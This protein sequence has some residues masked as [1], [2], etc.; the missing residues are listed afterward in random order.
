[1]ANYGYV[2]Y[3]T[4]LFGNL[5]LANPIDACAPID[6]VKIDQNKDISPIVLIK[7]GGCTFV[8]K[9][10][11]AKLIGAKMALIFDVINENEN[12]LLMID[13]GKGIIYF[14]IFIELIFL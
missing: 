5:F 4:K 12:D 14:Q 3:G 9:S 10:L 8:T 1:M 11:H 7:R 2:P 6:S 13:D